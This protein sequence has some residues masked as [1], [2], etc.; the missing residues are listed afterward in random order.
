[1][2]GVQTCALPISGTEIWHKEWILPNTNSVAILTSK[3]NFFFDNTG[4]A[5]FYIY[6][7]QGDIVTLEG[8]VL[9]PPPGGHPS[10]T[11]LLTINSDGTS[12]IFTTYRGAIADMAVEKSTGNVLIDWRQYVVNPAPFNTIPVAVNGTYQYTGVIAIDSNRNFINRTAASFTLGIGSLFPLGNLNFVTN[13]K[14]T[15]A[16]TLTIPNQTFTA[17]KHTPTWKFFEN[18]SLTKFV[19]HPEINNNVTNYDLMALHN[20]KFAVS[21]SYSLTNNSTITVNGT[22]LTTCANDPN[23]A[24]LFPVFATSQSDVFISQLTIDT[25]LSI[26]K[27][28]LSSLKLYPNPAT[29]YINLSFE[30]NLENASLKIVSLLGQTVLEK[31]NLSGNNVSFDVQNLSAGMYV[32]EVKD[33]DSLTNTKFIKD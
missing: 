32:I 30:N 28:K 16:E 15:P 26:S 4:K 9:T 19:A 2:T 27:N 29:N 21:G 24:T 10:T 22:T 11:S 31:Q 6:C 20:N 25:S 7:I 3:N 5:Y 14:M 12:G 23:F 33:G 1:M 8:T 17:T 18:F 13:T